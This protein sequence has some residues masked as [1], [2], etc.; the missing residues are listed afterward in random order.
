VGDR[1]VDLSACL[2]GR[3]GVAFLRN[4]HFTRGNVP[5]NDYAA[6]G[7]ALAHRLEE[8]GNPATEVPEVRHR[9]GSIIHLFG[10]R[11]CVRENDL[12]VAAI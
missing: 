6:I 11:G 10:I 1:G 3:S 5:I 7:N 9:S 2:P 12:N 4:D 8:I